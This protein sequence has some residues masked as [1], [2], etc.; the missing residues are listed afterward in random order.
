MFDMR[1]PPSQSSVWAVPPRSST[2]TRVRTQIS[3]LFHG[4]SVHTSGPFNSSSRG[5][6]SAC[7]DEPLPS[8]GRVDIPQPIPLPLFHS[9]SRTSTRSVIDPASSPATSTRPVRPDSY[10]RLIMSPA[11]ALQSTPESPTRSSAARWEELQHAQGSSGRRRRQHRR[12]RHGPWQ[13]VQ[14]SGTPKPGSVRRRIYSCLVSG[15][16]LVTVLTIC[17][18]CTRFHH[19]GYDRLM[20]L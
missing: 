20:Y 14:S 9:R 13:R 10:L 4:T 12:R 16:S 8:H 19:N 15:I 2:L 17:K 7:Q 6:K 18:F 5:L 3:A 1:L 11:L